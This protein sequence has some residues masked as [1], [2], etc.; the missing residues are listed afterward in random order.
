MK[1]PSPVKS[2]PAVTTKKGRGR[3]KGGA[4]VKVFNLNKFQFTLILKKSPKKA[5]PARA[6]LKGG[7]TKK[8]SGA[9]KRGRPKKNATSEESSGEQSDAGIF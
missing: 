2:P 5:A 8:A 7:V 9:G 3:P 6:T 1:P 4:V